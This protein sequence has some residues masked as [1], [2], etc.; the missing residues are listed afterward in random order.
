VEGPVLI[1]HGG[2]G[3]DGRW[4]QDVWVWPLP[5]PGPL[6]FVCEWPAEGVQLTRVEVDAGLVLEAAEQAEPLW[7]EQEQ[8]S[9]GLG[10]GGWTTTRLSGLVGRPE[11]PRGEHGSQE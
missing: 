3:G 6:A 9:L 5:P 7:E 2:G 4:D 8:P 11:E 10:R 1:Q